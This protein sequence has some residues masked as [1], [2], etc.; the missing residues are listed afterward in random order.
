MRRSWQVG[1]PLGAALP[2]WRTGGAVTPRDGRFGWYVSFAVI[3]VGA[4]LLIH[5]L[6]GQDAVAATARV[7]WNSL[8][9][10]FNTLVRASGELLAL[11]ARGVGLRR[12]ARL[13]NVVCGVGLG[14]MASVVMSEKAVHK[15]Q[16]WRGR[17][18]AALAAARQHWHGLHL[19]WKLLIVAGLI[20]SQVYLH[21]LLVVFPI[22]FL[23]PIVRRLWVQ[24]ADLVFGGWY[25]R[26][27]GTWHR[28]IVH[29]LRTVPG[30]RELI[31]WGRLTRLRYLTAWRL[32]KY[33]PRYRDPD[34]DRRAVSLIEP[35]RL[36]WRGDLDGYVRRPLCAGADPG[37]APTAVRL[38]A[39]S[40]CIPE[41]R[42]PAA[43]ERG[44]TRAVHS[45]TLPGAGPVAE[46]D[47]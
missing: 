23:V 19:V 16:G 17:L 25:W 13:A 10:L 29:F 28:T 27:F 3:A 44:W 20:A 7:L 1:E 38:S 24:A 47:L 42:G 14:Y 21:T 35:V 40:R 15:A 22:A 2:P 43:A 8:A 18:R 33:H 12:V 5:A 45:I 26:T 41:V 6:T 4:F 30:A 37:A 34:T 36:W 32:W 11:L 9:L 46:R 31:G 39:V